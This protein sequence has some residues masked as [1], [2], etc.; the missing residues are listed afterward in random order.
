M[1]VSRNGQRV[2]HVLAQGGLIR[3][4]RDENG[5]IS[6]I[7]CLTREGWLMSLCT[8]DLFKALRQKGLIAS[9]NGGPYRITRMGL[10]AVR[11]RH[12]NR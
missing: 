11:S 10:L 6:E 12:D 3:H 2:L 5:R 4:Y 9:S 8:L 1:N 7:E